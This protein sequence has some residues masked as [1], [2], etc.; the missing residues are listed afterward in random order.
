V[1]VNMNLLFN[2]PGALGEVAEAL[3][4]VLGVQLLLTPD[5]ELRPGCGP[6]PARRRGGRDLAESDVL[7]L[8]VLFQPDHSHA[9]MAGNPRLRHG[10]TRSPV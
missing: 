9:P 8:D 6:S 4:P 7:R 2:A 1:S 10:G 5:G 3:S